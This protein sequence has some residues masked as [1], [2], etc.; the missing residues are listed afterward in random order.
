MRKTVLFACMTV[1]CLAMT[2]C[3]KNNDVQESTEDSTVES[4]A[5]ESSVEDSSAEES[6]EDLGAEGEVTEGWSAE[7]EAIKTALVDKLGEN[8]WPQ[9]AVP[10]E[11]LEGNYGITA[12]MY[13]DYMAE[14]TM[15][16]TNVDTVIIVKAKEDQVQAVSDALNS[17]RDAMISDTMQYPMNVGKI[18]ASKIEVIGNYVCF[19]QLGADVMTALEQG[20]D[21]VIK[22]CQEQNDIALEVIRTT[23]VK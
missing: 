1:V 19:V 3:G 21:A 14:M 2:A 23:V 12:D 16:S 22:Q 11:I 10:A 6:A 15:M 17:Y 20:D 7:M 8:Y 5:V 9:M 13:D 18:Q 4:S